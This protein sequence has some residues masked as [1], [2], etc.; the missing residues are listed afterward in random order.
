MTADRWDRLHTLFAALADASSEERAARL[1]AG[2]IDPDL[3][4]DLADLLVAHDRERPLA[5][6]ARVVESQGGFVAGQRI[7]PYE[8]V[9]LLGRGGMG[10][11]WRAERDEG[12][13][14]RRVAIKRIRRGLESDELVRRFRIERQALARL[15]HRSIA[16][17]L[18][19]G[20]DP[21]GTP[22]LVLEH[23]EG[24]PITAACDDRRLGIDRRLALFEEVCHAV[25]FAHANL[26]V[27]RDLKP[28]NILVT[29]DDEVRLLDFGIAKL[30]AEADAEAMAGVDADVPRTRGVL[31]TPEYAS[32]E[33]LAG[34]PVTTATD[35]YALGVLL[36]ELLTGRRPFAQHESDG[37][38]FAREVT[39]RD[40]DPA[41]GVVTTGRADECIARAAARATTPVELARTLRGDLG[42]IVATALRRDPARRYA[43]ADRLAE[44]I[45]RWRAGRTIR[46]RPDSAMYRLRMFIGRNRI[47]VA[48]GLAGALVLAVLGVQLVV[49]SAIAARERDAA[50]AERDAANEVT[51]FLVSLFEVDP[52]ATG[53]M[54][55]DQRTLG[56]FIIAS[57]TKVRGELADRPELRARLTT[58]LARLNA[59]LGRH[60]RAV[61]LAGEAV[62]ERRRLLGAQ[63]PELA[64]SLN[65]LGT[66]F[67]EQGDYAKAE[68]VFREALAIREQAYG[69]HHADT[70]E[71]VNNLAVLLSMRGDGDRDEVERLE[72]RGLALRRA[73]FGD[74]HLDTAQSLNNLGVFL[75]LRRTGDDVDAAAELLGESLAIR[76]GELGRDH[77]LVANSR[78]NFANALLLTARAD[79]AEAMFHEAIRAW[80]ASLGPNHVRVA[81]GWWGLSKA[82]ERRGD[83]EGAIDAVRRSLAIDEAGLPVD[84]PNLSSARE[85]LAELE[86]KRAGTGAGT[87]GTGS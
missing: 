6:E 17:L 51:A 45:A 67:Q 75:F 42:T 19:A 30:L 81:S 34:E 46:A 79:E 77:P 58:M 40:A 85:R 33:Q 25:A 59:N 65:I 21:H 56:D 52:F 53:D 43:S 32:P 3:A 24:T 62:D 7:G 4:A 14:R 63:S 16:H 12:G 78:S 84:H 18:D 29:K 11:V 80:S 31:A 60:A 15:A 70:A 61:E 49:Q 87:R 55:P 50:R 76:E 1:A 82:L 39:A 47:A 44:D 73:V 5:L 71:S 8:L 23:V 20:V 13:Y 69:D 2:D 38:G 27:H 36:H 35:V 57:E 10:E 74:R 72:R 26:V 41:A 37:L 54:E 48:A 66:A 22:Y 86:A 68:P 83:L 28:G 9:E 64:E